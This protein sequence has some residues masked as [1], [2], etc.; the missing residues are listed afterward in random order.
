MSLSP[1]AGSTP[2]VSE[3]V[4]STEIVAE[5]NN[6]FS[7]DE[8]KSKD[9]AQEEQIIEE[10]VALPEER[11]APVNSGG[12]GQTRGTSTELAEEVF[13]EEEVD[14]TEGR[15]IDQAC[16]GDFNLDLDGDADLMDHGLGY[17]SELDAAP[18]VLEDFQ[19]NDDF[20]GEEG[21]FGASDSNWGVTDTSWTTWGPDS[22]PNREL[23]MAGQR[24]YNQYQ[25]AY[26]IAGTYNLHM[27]DTYGD[28]WNSAWLTAIDTSGRQL[29]SWTV[30]N[31][32]I[33]ST[34]FF[35][36]PVY[37]CTDPLADNY[38]NQATI[39][40]SSCIYLNCYDNKGYVIYLDG[41]SID[42]TYL[43]AHTVTGLDAGREY[44]VSVASVYNEGISDTSTIC[45]VPWNNVIFS[46][47]EL[48]FDSSIPITYQE[49]EL[50]IGVMPGYDSS[51][52]FRFSSASMP[53]FSPDESMFF[54]DFNLGMTNMYDPSGLFGGLWQT[55]NAENANSNYFDYGFSMDSSDFAWINDDLIGAAGGAENAY[56][57]TDEITILSGEKVFV[58][59]DVLFPQPCGSCTYS[60]EYCGGIEGEGYSE[61]LFLL[62]STNYGETWVK[63]DTTM[64]TGTWNWNSRMYNIT[65][66]INGATSFI[67]A[68]FYND[69]NGNWAFGVGIDNFAVNIGEDT[70]WLTISPYSGILEPGESLNTTVRV[71]T[72]NNDIINE[73]VQLSVANEI[74]NIPIVINPSLSSDEYD[75]PTEYRL[76]QNFPNPFNPI[77][78][79]PFDIATT[80][81][82]QFIIY[83][84]LGEQVASL[85][86]KKLNAGSHTV[87]WN[88]KSDR[89][90]MMP[91]GL[92]FY[93]IRTREFR[94]TGKM[95]FI[96]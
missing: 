93:E 8:D 89:G 1:M 40:D 33:D 44:C 73:S 31:G 46:P 27:K 87:T 28:G 52:L 55:G 38:N 82:V 83:N 29:L 9:W 76:G 4:G 7:E 70:D 17:P 32:F 96:K 66:A 22:G 47:L 3:T 21:Y 71:Y 18:E 12:P 50:S 77:T 86:H 64:G 81:K 54:A 5:Q 51:S 39:D 19:S 57:V 43:S 85:L 16:T 42:F 58:S 35:A 88:G 92:Y 36:G 65:D 59:F 49:Q 14:E 53:V 61:D 11:L 72:D 80:E 30:E 78:I 25:T 60:I 10:D 69:C 90:V 84:I 15:V 74:L 94:D 67:L 45:A 24:N 48:S 41:D 95:L 6:D 79:I 56:L 91:A 26:L 20:T 23:V 37:G 62:L 75:I 13:S 63:I 34:Y 2:L 68:F